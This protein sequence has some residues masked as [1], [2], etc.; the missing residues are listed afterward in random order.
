MEHAEQR[1]TQQ[2]ARMVKDVCQFQAHETLR[3]NVMLVCP[4]KADAFQSNTDICHD[5]IQSTASNYS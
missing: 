1:G 3:E 2:K 5:W 4:V